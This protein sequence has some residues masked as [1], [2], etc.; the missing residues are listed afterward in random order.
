MFHNM[1]KIEKMHPAALFFLGFIFGAIVLG[2][3]FFYQFL[4]PDDYKSSLLRGRVQ[5]MAPPV[6]VPPTTVPPVFTPTRDMINTGDPVPFIPMDAV[7]S[8][9]PIPF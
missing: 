1:F 8:G 9:D 2:L 7:Y 3:F 6:E 4:Q 5:M